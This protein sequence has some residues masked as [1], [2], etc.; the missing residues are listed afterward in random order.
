M[1]LMGKAHS[2]SVAELLTEL[3]S[4]GFSYGQKL[5]RTDHFILFRIASF[6]DL[7]IYFTFLNINEHGRGRM[8]SGADPNGW[9]LL[10]FPW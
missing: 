2:I 3:Q 6:S 1:E 7:F 5:L 10:P 4:E 8:G 9:K